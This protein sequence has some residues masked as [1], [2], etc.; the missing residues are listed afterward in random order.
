LSQP[1]DDRQD[2]LFRTS[3][4]AIINL[5]HPL[6]RLAA[7][8]NWD[9]LAKR[10]S[11]V[12]RVGP[13]QPPLPTRLVAGL[14]IL[15]HMHNFSDEALCDRWVENPYFQYFCG[16]AVF[17]HE[18][19]FDRSSLTRWRQRLG[20][21]QIAALLQESLSVAHRSGAIET[22]DLERV[23]VDTT[24]QEKAIAHPT[25]ARLMHRAIE[26][27]VDLA[28]REGVKLRQSYLRL[29][30]RA[31]I[32]VG[33][34]THAHQFKR[35]RRELKFLRTRLGRIIRDIRRKIEDDGTLEDRFGPLLDLALRVR[36]QEQRQRGPKVYSLH[37]PEVECIGKGKART[38]YEFGCKVSIVTPVTAPKGGQFVLHAKAL[39]GNPYDGHTLAPVIADLE[40]LTGVAVRRIHG[41]KGY[42]GHNYPYRFKVWISGQLRR[43]T[44]AIRREMRRRAAVEPVIGHLKDD[45]RMRRNHLKGRE[46][47]RIN[48]VLAAAGYN[49]SLLLRWFRQFLRVLLLIFGQPLAPPRLA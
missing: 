8:I 18:L 1:R 44:K 7:E 5:R 6:V 12:C 38:P 25:D 36:H 15:K 23:V 11:S 46:G 10:F 33:R 13:G 22:K 24:V 39:H 30:K 35:A 32:M 47:D 20:E 21:E 14:F 4:E 27:L 40:K 31:A 29:A 16:E 9:F 3:L 28:K 2:D 34:Y 19:P 17:R 43:V 26:K 48:A 37:A 45:H 41:D 42:R 49:F